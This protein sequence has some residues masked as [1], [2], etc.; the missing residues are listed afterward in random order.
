M[1]SQNLPV[2]ISGE[3]KV[4]VK[5]T[6]RFNFSSTCSQMQVITALPHQSPPDNIGV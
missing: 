4:A 1:L 6:S 3:V 2:L 5:T